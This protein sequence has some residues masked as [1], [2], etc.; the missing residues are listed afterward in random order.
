VVSTRATLGALEGEHSMNK[1]IILALA[2]AGTLLGAG[3]AQAADVRWSV[4]INLPVPGLVITG[5]PVYRQYS[6]YSEYSGYSEYREPARVYAPVPIYAP[7]PVYYQPE[8]VY[9]QPEPVYYYPR[10]SQW[11]R[12]HQPVPV[13][14]APPYQPGWQSVAYPR[15][16]DERRE[17]RREDHREWRH[18]RRD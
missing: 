5:G 17:E 12:H 10:Q 18:D 2:V 15:Y 14:A 11:H 16:H 1:S 4:G 6:P 3:A 13:I 7:A 9:V 8:P